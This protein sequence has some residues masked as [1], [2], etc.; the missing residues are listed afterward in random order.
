VHV[1]GCEGCGVCTSLP[2][3]ACVDGV[4]GVDGGQWSGAHR[5][6]WSSLMSVSMLLCWL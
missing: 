1:L 3:H 2:L 5:L 6:S 4:D